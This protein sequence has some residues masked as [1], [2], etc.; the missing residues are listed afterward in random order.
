MLDFTEFNKVATKMGFGTSA[1][2]IFKSLDHDN[3]GEISYMEL[4]ESF[5]TAPPKNTEVKQLCTS[6]MFA[7]KEE[8]TST[9][10]CA[11]RLDTSGWTI[12][13]RDVQ[14]IRRELQSLLRDSG[15][16]VGE[17]M[18]LFDQDQHGKQ[19]IDDMEFSKAM[20]EHCGYKGPIGLLFAT[21]KSLD[22]DSSGTIGF[23]ELFEFIRGRRHSLDKRSKPKQVMRLQPPEGA[24]YS[25]DDLMW[26][27]ETLRILM[28]QMLERCNANP[29]DLLAQFQHSKSNDGV[30]DKREFLSMMRSMLNGHERLWEMTVRAVADAAFEEIDVKARSLIPGSLDLVEISRWL[31][32]PTLRPQHLELVTQPKP[33]QAPPKKQ[34][35]AQATRQAAEGS[36]TLK[37]SPA[38]PG[39]VKSSPVPPAEMRREQQGGKAE[40]HKGEHSS[41]STS[42]RRASSALDSGHSSRSTTSSLCGETAAVP[43]PELTPPYSSRR[44]YPA[45][46]PD[47][48]EEEA[49]PAL[50]SA[51]EILDLRR[52]PLVNPDPLVSTTVEHA[53]LSHSHRYPLPVMRKR[54]QPPRPRVMMRSRPSS[55]RPISAN[56][57]PARPISARSPLKPPVSERLNGRGLN[58]QPPAS[59][60]LNGWGL[61]G[62][63]L[64]DSTHASEA[65]W[66]GG[67]PRSA[68]AAAGSSIV[69]SRISSATSQS[70]RSSSL[71][72]WGSQHSQKSQ[73]PIDSSYRDLVGRTS[74][75]VHHVRP[76]LVKPLLVELDTLLRL[77]CHA[78]P[79]TVVA[80]DPT[81]Q[82]YGH[83]H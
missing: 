28:M 79:V 46:Q 82:G 80:I 58:D 74:R 20:R 38:K 36:Q 23:D 19:E 67:H 26:D 7:F 55:A 11:P 68:M 77:P 56:L 3:S 69:G 14:T 66:R 18:A 45:W 48:G 1:H 49:A 42:S 57:G 4:I 62:Q 9:A 6:L 59:A 34:K 22:T 30:L 39:Q 13:G 47:Q 44:D 63:G 25:L 51:A 71:T 15:A 24:E 29:Y 81:A 43:R 31:A 64:N 75:Q 10:S 12:K 72:N 60:R 53:Y 70:T 73:L 5:N 40:E 54:G 78:L 8:T 27:C 2:C 61:N 17:V 41:S 76:C 35:R 50:R 21:F 16:H 65:A 33:A 32:A 52:N 37:S 83:L